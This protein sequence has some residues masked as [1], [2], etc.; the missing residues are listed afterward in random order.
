MMERE[1]G[2]GDGEEVPMLVF[3]GGKTLP[4]DWSLKILFILLITHFTLK[5]FHP[6]KR[7]EFHSTIKNEIKSFARNWMEL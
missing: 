6:L 1:R 2:T 7:V 4:D 3:T 5:G